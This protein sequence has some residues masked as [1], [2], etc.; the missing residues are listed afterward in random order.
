MAQVT[1]SREYK[2][3]K[4]IE[5]AVNQYGFNR[6]NFIAGISTMHRTLQ[7]SMFRDIIL[8]IIYHFSHPKFGYDDRNKAAHFL[9]EELQKTV[10]EVGSYL[11]HI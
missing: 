9:A 3:A 1:E 11:P 4:A 10:S 2:L 7:Q 6:D 8:P 5:D